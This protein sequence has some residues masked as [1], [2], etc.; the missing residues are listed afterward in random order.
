MRI[1]IASTALSFAVLG[2]AAA[3]ADTRITDMAFVHAAR[4]AGL[5]EGSGA[6]ASAA[7]AVLKAQSQGRADYIRDKADQARNDAAH[8]IRSL[9]GEKHDRLVAERDGACAALKSS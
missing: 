6:D 1:L 8:D 2:A 5:A 9:K 7:L 4:C 3:S